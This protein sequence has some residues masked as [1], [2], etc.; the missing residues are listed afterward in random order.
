MQYSQS[1]E[2]MDYKK[3]SKLKSIW[4]LSSRDEEQGKDIQL[5]LE[6]YTITVL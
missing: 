2:R 6:G 3:G 5:D 1:G 4:Y